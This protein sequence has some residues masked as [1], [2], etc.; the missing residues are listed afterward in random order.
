[1]LDWLSSS[2]FRV[3]LWR[4]FLLWLA[5]KIANA[6]TAVIAKVPPLAFRPGTE[7]VACAI[8]L[9]VLWVF[10]RSDNEDLLLGNLGVNLRTAFGPLA[11]LHFMLSAMLS[12]IA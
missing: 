9:F 4:F 12:L 11:V 2:L 5:G 3:Y 8:E 10:V 7:L 1:M 6:A